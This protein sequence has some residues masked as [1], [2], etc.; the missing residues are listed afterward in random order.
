MSIILKTTI[1]AKVN[2]SGLEQASIV[3]EVQSF[4]NLD[5]EISSAMEREIIRETVASVPA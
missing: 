1:A 2:K 4:Q 3:L 5:S